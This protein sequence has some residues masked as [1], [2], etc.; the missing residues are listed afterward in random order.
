MLYININNIFDIKV[1]LRFLMLP[2]AFCPIRLQ[3]ILN[4]SEVPVIGQLFGDFQFQRGF[5]IPGGF[6]NP[7][8]LQIPR[9]LK[10]PGYCKSPG[11]CKSHRDFKSPQE[12]ANRVA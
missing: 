12:I 2:H 6:E 5:V 9:G 3:F 7:G 11:D 10:I 1:T 4:T 8:G